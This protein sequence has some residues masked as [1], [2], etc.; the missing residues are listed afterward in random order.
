MLVMAPL[1]FWKQ[2]CVVCVCVF[3]VNDACC[4][5]LWYILKTSFF[6][7]SAAKVLFT[8]GAFGLAVSATIGAYLTVFLTIGASSLAVFL[9]IIAFG[10]AV[11]LT[12]GALGLA[13]FL[14]LLFPSA[15]SWFAALLRGGFGKSVVNAPLPV[16][17]GDST[18]SRGS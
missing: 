6:R 7:V 12:I 18:A 5:A 1:V 3:L 10:L 13:A 17:S 11:F 9:T 14:R 16:G 2:T 15:L 8:I 4:S